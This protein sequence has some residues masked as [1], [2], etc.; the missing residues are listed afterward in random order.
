MKLTWHLAKSQTLIEPVEHEDFWEARSPPSEL[1][2]SP[3]GPSLA[4][5]S[6]AQP[7]VRSKG[8]K[9]EFFFGVEVEVEVE[10]VKR[11]GF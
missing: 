10:G 6:P 8:K 5:P 7:K 2:L 11:N 3:A 4:W 1:R 9:K